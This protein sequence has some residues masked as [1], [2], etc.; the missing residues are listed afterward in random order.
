VDSQARL[1]H[2]NLATMQIYPPI[3]AERMAAWVA[4]RG[5]NK[6]NLSKLKYG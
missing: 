6:R 2:I 4:K 3:D 1:G 5:W